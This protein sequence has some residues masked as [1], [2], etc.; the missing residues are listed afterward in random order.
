[1]NTSQLDTLVADVLASAKYRHVSPELVRLIGIRELAAHPKIRD[2]IK[3]TKNK[4][5]Q[6]GGAYLSIT[7]RYVEWCNEL[8]KVVHDPTLL[9]AACLRIMQQHASTRE[10]LPILEQFYA[11]IFQQ[12][13]P[14]QQVL[15][16]A[17][18]LNPLALDWMPLAPHPIYLACDIY[19]DMVGFV[20][21]FLTLGQISGRAWVCDLVSSPP[22]EAVDLVL[23]LKVL[24]VLEQIEK[25]TALRLLRSLNAPFILVSFPAQSLGGRN[26]GM[27]SHYEQWFES[28][29]AA[30]RWQIMRFSF[31]TELA[32]LIHKA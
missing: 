23:V 12:L 2:A 1:M 15:D 29:I 31:S 6:V 21:Q 19:A 24:P 10:R 11:Q 8:T 30:E 16:V 3:E 20:G 28:L 4:L 22:T 26:K 25:G 5:H 13:P 18:G 14:I 17:C 7:P 9:R 32:F 27:A